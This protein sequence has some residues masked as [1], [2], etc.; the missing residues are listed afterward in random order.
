MEVD[1]R[2]GL[3]HTGLA[4]QKSAEARELVEGF[5]AG[6]NTALDKDGTGVDQRLVQGRHWVRP[7]TASS[8]LRLH[9]RALSPSRRRV[10]ATR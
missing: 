7:I 1:R 4:K 10:G 3:A 9:A 5:A 6:W 8:S 2:A